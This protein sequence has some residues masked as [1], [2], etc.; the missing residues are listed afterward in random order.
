MNKGKYNIQLISSS[1]ELIHAVV[2]Y[3]DDEAPYCVT[4]RFEDQKIQETAENV[5][6]AFTGIRRILE[7][8]ELRPVCFGASR[9]VYP[10]A[11]ALSMGAGVKAYRLTMGTPAMRS[12]LVHIFKNDPSV[13]PV[14]PPEQA[15]FYSKWINSL[16]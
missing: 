9:N 8:L 5:F 4:L 11:M 12:D 6:T 14:Y 10:S 7:R 13:N 2:E 3:D 1:G 15:E 16:Q